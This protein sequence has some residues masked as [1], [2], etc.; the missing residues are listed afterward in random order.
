M[1]RELLRCLSAMSSRKAKGAAL[2][3]D[4]ATVLA[5]LVQRM[6]EERGRK[7]DALL[8]SVIDRCV[9]GYVGQRLA[10]AS[11]DVALAVAS[12]IFQDDLHARLVSQVMTV[13]IRV[14][15]PC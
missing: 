4:D 15:L 1:A 10:E 6:L 11:E 2:T 3:L 7:V 13:L 9:R 14:S 5:R 8:L 12:I